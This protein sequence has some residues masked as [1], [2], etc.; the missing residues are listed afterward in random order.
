MI[1]DNGRSCNRENKIMKEQLMT[2]FTK[3]IYIGDNINKDFKTPEELGMKYLY[4][5]NPKGLYYKKTSEI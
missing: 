3:M 5:E 4:F 1:I 2:N